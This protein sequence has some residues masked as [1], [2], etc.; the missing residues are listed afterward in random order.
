MTQWDTKQAKMDPNNF[1]T[2][3]TDQTHRGEASLALMK[4]YL[5]IFCLLILEEGHKGRRYIEEFTIY[6]FFSKAA[7]C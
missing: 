1:H 6:I 5:F 7:E 4:R 3:P 2:T